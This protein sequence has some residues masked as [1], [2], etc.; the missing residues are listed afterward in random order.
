METGSTRPTLDTTPA[1]ASSKPRAVPAGV[2]PL[3]GTTNLMFAP[4]MFLALAHVKADPII[5]SFAFFGCNRTEK[6]AWN[7]TLNPSSANL[8]QL[9]RTFADIAALKPRPS[10]LFVLGDLVLGYGDDQGQEVKGQL[11]AWY[12]EYKSSPIAKPPLLIPVSGNHELNRKV[13]KDKLPSSF[14]AAIWNG[15]LEKYRLEPH[16]ANGPKPGKAVDTLDDQTKLNFTFD[17]GSLRFIALNTDFRTS[18]GKVA[19]IATDWAISE[20]RK[21]DAQGK[22]VILMGH[23]N[24]VDPTSATG[25]S[26]VDRDSSRALLAEMG[27]HKNVIA[28][29]C[30]H[31]HAWDLTRINSTGPWQ[32]VA[33]NGGSKLEKD[34]HPGKG[35]YFGFSVIEVHKS[36]SITLARYDREANALPHPFPAVR[37][38]QANLG[39]IQT[40]SLQRH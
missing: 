4:L 1:L 35:T 34:W 13:G 36:G 26:P 16:V 18:S 25:D 17:R 31:V 39:R 23:R 37:S 22:S 33:G 7:P 20:I 19:L 29:L 32:V 24:L 2:S 10:M 15:W 12:S 11:D 9:R 28:Y 3:A 14:T 40:R 38:F 30:A 5:D 27:K 21:A 8:P 6:D